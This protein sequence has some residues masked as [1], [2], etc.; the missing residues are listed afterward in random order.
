[1]LAA[2]TLAL[3]THP[4][5]RRDAGHERDRERHGA[6]YPGGKP[7]T[8]PERAP[9]GVAVTLWSTA[10]APGAAYVSRLRRTA[11]GTSNTILRLAR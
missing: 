10:L 8:F 7:P 2:F 11:D 6:G 5:A 4:T 3:S 9:E 1:V